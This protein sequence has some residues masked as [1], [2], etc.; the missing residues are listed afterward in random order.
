M[1]GEKVITTT[2][3]EVAEER[4]EVHSPA[5]FVVGEVVNLREQLLLTS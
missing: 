1:P 5:V 2:F 3:R 4:V